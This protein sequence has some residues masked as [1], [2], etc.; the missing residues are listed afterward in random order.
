MCVR[1]G[2]GRASPG[3]V[4]ARGQAASGRVGAMAGEARSFGAIATEANTG[5]KAVRRFRLPFHCQG[6]FFPLSG[7]QKSAV[8]ARS[9]QP[10]RIISL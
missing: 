10:G 3:R 5:A 9:N 1:I 6:V 7:A 8:E 4:R 2:F